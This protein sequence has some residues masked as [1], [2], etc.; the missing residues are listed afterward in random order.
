MSRFAALALAFVLVG[1]SDWSL[2]APTRPDLPVICAKSRE[3]CEAAVTAIHDGRWPIEEPYTRCV[4]KANCFSAES[5]EIRGFND[6]ATRT[7]R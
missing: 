7:R 1:A 6:A 4:P 3:V 2:V 5:D